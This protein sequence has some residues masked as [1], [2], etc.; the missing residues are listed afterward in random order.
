MNLSASCISLTVLTIFCFGT[1]TAAELIGMSLPLSGRSAPIAEQMQTGAALAIQKVRQA[2]YDIELKFA[3][4]IDQNRG[5]SVSDDM[6][7]AEFEEPEIKV[8]EINIQEVW[9]TPYTGYYKYN[10]GRVVSLN[11]L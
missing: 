7:L 8:M 11:C 10:D 5:H 6:L 4:G 3:D 9:N 1:A 2:G